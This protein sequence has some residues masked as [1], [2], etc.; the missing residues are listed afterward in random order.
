MVASKNSTDLGSQSRMLIYGPSGCG[1]TAFASACFNEAEE[2]DAGWITT[3]LIASQILEDP[4]S[5]INRAF[6]GIQQYGVKGLLIEDAD[7]LFTS[8]RSN[9]ASYQLLFEKIEGTQM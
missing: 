9:P 7:Y 1:K 8:L 4:M 2:S 6:E 3:A 5:N